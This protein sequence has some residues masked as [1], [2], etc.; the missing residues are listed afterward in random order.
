MNAYAHTADDEQGLPLPVESGKWQPLAEHLRNVA[1]SA[2]RLAAPF[3]AAQEARAAGLL[4]D[5]GKYGARFQARLRDPRITGINHWAAGAVQAFQSGWRVAAFPVDGHHTGLPPARG[6]GGMEQTLRKFL[7]EGE[8]SKL[9]GCT[10]GLAELL[11]RLAADGI[12]APPPV[13]PARGDYF[14]Q[15]LRA[16]F[17]LSAL[18]DAD[19]LD[20]EAHFDTSKATSRASIALQEQEALRIL[21]AHIDAKSSNSDLGRLRAELLAACLRQ[22]ESAPGVFSLTAPTGSGKTLSSLAFALRHIVHH[23]RGLLPGDDRRFRRVIVVIPYTSIIEQTSGVFRGVFAGAFGADYVLEHHSNVAPDPSEALAAD[24]QE[25]RPRRARLA[26][27]NWSAPLIV[28]TSVRFFES[29]F[30]NRPSAC[31]RL[32]SIARSVVLFD[33]VQTLPPSLAPSLLSAVRLLDRDYGC[34]TVFMTATQPAF[35]GVPLA[36]GVPRWAPVEINPRPEAFAESLRR[37]D[38]VMEP[39]SEVR[40][41]P[42]VAR[43]LVAKEQA[44]CV[45]NTTA[46]ARDLYRLLPAESRFHL[47]SRLCPAHRSVVLS[48]VRARLD[49]RNSRP[50]LLVSTQLIEAGVDVD[51]PVVHRAFGPLDSLIQSAGRCNREGRLPARGRFTVFHPADDRMP[52]GTYSLATAKTR[53][54]LARYPDAPLDSPATFARYFEEFYRLAGPDAADR[55]TV[56]NLSESFDFPG[57]AEKC[58][59]I[60]DDT[61]AVLVDWGGGAA[62]AEKLRRKGHLTREECREAQAFSV[63]L[64]A[65]E[66]LVARACGAT[67]QPAAGFDIW[68][69]KGHYDSALGAIAAEGADCIL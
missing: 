50:C 34:S 20:T 31:R 10:E 25:T 65:G 67:E 17:L 53:E 7:D 60:P 35:G 38:V 30:S 13:A 44:L 68:V 32:H 27:E 51:F 42:E 29:L 16:R 21:L 15:A 28:T 22:A 12:D 11:S 33:E 14:A 36:S 56:L 55:D 24:A 43:R 9:T 52:R 6:P 59:L 5:L 37:V 1:D 8:R 39:A 57:A 48:E 26:A 41:W 69:W 54:F 45:V 47:S 58:R 63:N 61:Q 4:H 23:N 64:H 66:F 49:A 3:G 19:F 46:Q 40:D 62:L 18:A 2:A